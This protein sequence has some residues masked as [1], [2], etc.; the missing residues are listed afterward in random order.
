MSPLAAENGP[1]YIKYRLEGHPMVNANHY[2]GS[3]VS[4]TLEN[5]L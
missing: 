3:T 1:C 5:A 2:P 4:E